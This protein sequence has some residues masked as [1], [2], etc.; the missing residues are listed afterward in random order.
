MTLLVWAQRVKHEKHGH[1]KTPNRARTDASA[2]THAPSR[3]LHTLQPRLQRTPRRELRQPH[4]SRKPT[5]LTLTRA[6]RSSNTSKRH[7]QNAPNS[8]TGTAPHGRNKNNKGRC[9]G[10]ARGRQ[11]RGQRLLDPRHA[12]LS[13]RSLNKHGHA[14]KHQVF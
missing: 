1:K 5:F 11:D 2:W 14:R 9:D 8:A 7:T 10:C 4:A 12:R 6:W 3:L 13:I